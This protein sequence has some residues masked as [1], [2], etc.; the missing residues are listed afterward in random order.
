M[1][2]VRRI[3]SLIL[4][5]TLMFYCTGVAKANDLDDIA[6]CAGMI[7]GNAAVDLQL[8]DEAAFD[9]GLRVA[10]TGY[11]SFVSSGSFS[12]DHL[13]L[14]DQIMASNTDIIINAANTDTYDY[15]VYESLLS[16]YRLLGLAII[17]TAP[18]I[19]ANR[20]LIEETVT[21]KGSLIKRF[22][23]AGR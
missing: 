4:T 6:A 16:C 11:L 8:D 22:I 17:T 12:S 1:S 21:Q 10:I 3:W 19:E 13:N 15:E 7:I 5:S 20:A 14:A 18:N 9:E 23:R 2:R